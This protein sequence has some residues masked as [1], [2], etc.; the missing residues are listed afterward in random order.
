MAGLFFVPLGESIFYFLNNADIK[1]V[2][3]FGHMTGLLFDPLG[4]SRFF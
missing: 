4:E 1:V 3:L 2:L